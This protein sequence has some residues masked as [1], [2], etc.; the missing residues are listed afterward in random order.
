LR[1]IFLLLRFIKS[2]AAFNKYN[3]LPAYSWSPK[4]SINRQA[5][6]L[7]AKATTLFNHVLIFVCST[8]SF[9]HNYSFHLHKLLVPFKKHLLI[10]REDIY[11]LKQIS[12]SNQLAKLWFFNF[13]SILIE[14]LSIAKN[15]Q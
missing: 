12:F 7:L 13:I 10:N 1:H 14:K 3:K 5:P 4:A 9:F 2:S 15:H 6:L 11:F 8:F